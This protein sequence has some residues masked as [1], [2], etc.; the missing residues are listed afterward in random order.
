MVILTPV[1]RGKGRELARVIRRRNRWSYLPLFS[2]KREGIGTSYWAPG[3]VKMVIINQSL[4]EKEENCDEL[5]GAVQDG[6]HTGSY[7]SRLTGKRKRTGM[8]YWAPCRMEVTQGHTYP[9]LKGKR[10]GIGMRYWAPCKIE[11]T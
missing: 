2:V 10:K 6:G 8:R 1:S 5:L 7:I 9:R 3:E 4:R 11:V